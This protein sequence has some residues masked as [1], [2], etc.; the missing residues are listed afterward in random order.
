MNDIVKNILLF[1]LGCVLLCVIC[2]YSMNDEDEKDTQNVIT[3]DVITITEID[4]IFIKEIQKPSI[5]KIIDSVT[6]LDTIIQ[7]DT[8]R[9]FT[10]IIQKHYT[11]T[12]NYD[13][14]IS[15]CT[16]LK[17]DSLQIYKQNTITK[18]TTYIEKKPK[19]IY[20]GGK[21]EKHKESIIP[22]ISIATTR[23]KWL[24]GVDLGYYDNNLIYGLNVKYKIK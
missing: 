11:D 16:P 12:N 17:L 4:T 20:L 21:I 7:K 9:I 18:E 19:G 23:D 15:G 6:I 24:V 8:I 13:L 14:W 10:P 1:L 2:Y 22:Y 3:K 5:Q